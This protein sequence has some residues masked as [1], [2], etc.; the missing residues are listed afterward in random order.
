MLLL[1]LVLFFF[2]MVRRPPRATRTDTP[3]PYTTLFRSPDAP[4]GG[5][6]R[7]LAV[8]GDGEVARH[9]VEADDRRIRCA[10]RHETVSG[11][12][13]ADLCRAL[14]ERGEFA[15]VAR[16]GHRRRRGNAAR[17][18]A[19]AHDSLSPLPGQIGRAHVSTPVT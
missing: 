10:Q 16:I 17:P 15:L 9:R 5:D 14:D 13:R 3:L 2:L 19:P 7:R 4:A 1:I 8:G 6:T 18:V 11:A 12:D